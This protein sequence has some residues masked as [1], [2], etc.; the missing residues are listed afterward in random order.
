MRPIPIDR[1]RALT[2]R[3]GTEEPNFLVPCDPEYAFWQERFVASRSEHNSLFER[4]AFLRII[5]LDLLPHSNLWL[6]I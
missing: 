3:A 5:W 6:Q 1:Q 4:R 2:C